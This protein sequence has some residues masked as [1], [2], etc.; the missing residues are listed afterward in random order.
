MC[1]ELAEERSQC[2]EVASGD[3]EAGFDA[4]PDCYVDRDVQEVGSVV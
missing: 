2:R 4:A 3:C 1:E